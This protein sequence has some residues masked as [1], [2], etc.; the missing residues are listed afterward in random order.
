MRKYLIYIISIAFAFGQSKTETM[1]N[2]V[3]LNR[4]NNEFKLAKKNRSIIESKKLDYR[5]EY[6]INL[7]QYLGSQPQT[8][9]HH[10]DFYY[11]IK[12]NL[13]VDTNIPEFMLNSSSAYSQKY[14]KNL[15]GRINGSYDIGLCYYPLD[16][17]IFNLDARTY[18]DYR[19]MS[20]GQSLGV[21][22]FGFTIFNFYE[23][24]NTDKDWTPD[25]ID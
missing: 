3:D 8:F 15:I 6:S 22:I 12:E 17:G 23:N 16:N 7:G 20:E 2:S 4:I 1:I 9:G 11:I 18:N 21:G 25:Y 10:Q 14:G 19:G 24:G 13:I 5:Q